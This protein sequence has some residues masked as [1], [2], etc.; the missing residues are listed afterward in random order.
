MYDLSKDVDFAELCITSE[1]TVS[2][3]KKNE[4]EILVKTYKAEGNKCPVCWKIRKNKCERH[5]HLS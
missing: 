3:T 5:G 4:E 1:A 2:H